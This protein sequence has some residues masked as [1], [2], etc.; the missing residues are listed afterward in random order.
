[1]T[2]TIYL[3]V[4]ILSGIKKHLQNNGLIFMSNFVLASY[5]VMHE[6]ILFMGYLVEFLIKLE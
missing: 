6:G 4:T 2:L 5:T 3:L 1:M